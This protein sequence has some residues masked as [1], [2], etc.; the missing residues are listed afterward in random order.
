MGLSLR[1]RAER[2]TPTRVRLTRAG[3]AVTMAFALLAVFYAWTA[4]SSGNPFTKVTPFGFSVGDSD[5]Y[6]LQADAFLHGRLWV[7]VPID[8]QL[9]TAENPYALSNVQR[10]PDGSFYQGR[11]YLTW[12]PAPAVTTF[13]PPR[14]VGLRIQENLAVTLYCFFGAVFGAMALTLLVRRLVPGTPRAVIWTGGATIA[15]ATSMPWSLR[16]ATVYQVAITAAFFFVTAGLFV[17]LRELLR[18]Q[19]PR[20]APLAAAGTLFGLAVLSRPTMVFVVIGITVLAWLLRPETRRMTVPLIVGIPVIAGIIFMIYNMAR[21][22]GP[23]DFGNKWQTGV[24]DVTRAPYG[25]VANVPPALYAYLVAPLHMTL[26]FPYFHLPPPPDAPLASNSMYHGEA[27]GSMLWAV[28]FTLLALAFLARRRPAATGDDAPGLKPVVLTLLAIG[29]VVLTVGAY[30]IP[31]YTE[32]Y[33]LDFLPWIVM[34]ATLSWAS[35]IHHAPTPQR[36]TRWRRSGIALATWSI[37]VGVAVSFTGTYNGLDLRNHDLFQ[38]LERTFSPLPTIATKIA[39]R[40]MIAGI[41]ALKGEVAIPARGGYTTLDIPDAI[42]PLAPRQ[43]AKLTIVSPNARNARLTFLTSTNM[44]GTLTV[45]QTGAG[46]KTSTLVRNGSVTTLP[47]H[48]QGGVNYVTLGMTTG[49]D[50]PSG[51][52]IGIV[53]F[54]VRLR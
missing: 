15:L 6:N 39:G 38:S 29:V 10:L 28:P 3:I 17:L 41:Q 26:G 40:P 46:H 52:P 11:Y 30:G 7:D 18:E 22:S 12:G 54:G 31:G 9:L 33:K 45:F 34:A 24:R 42:F 13:L 50:L 23:L 36:A 1:S 8:P 19:P 43:P 27:T 2:D 35:L 5:Y 48:F 37:L 51:V 4:T 47:L 44:P 14:L 53:L 21:F 16:S 32:R 20:R 49:A 25:D